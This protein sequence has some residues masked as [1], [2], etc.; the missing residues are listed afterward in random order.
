MVY[1]SNRRVEDFCGD[2][3]CEP[4]HVIFTDIPY[5]LSNTSLDKLLINWKQGETAGAKGFMNMDWDQIPPP[6][7]WA[8]LR[9]L[10]H[11]GAILATF[12]GTKNSDL[13]SLSIRL[14][15][16]ERIDSI[17]A[18]CYANG[19]PKSR[20]LS[21]YMEP[22]HRNKWKGYGTAL[23]PSVEP[24]LLFRNPKTLTFENNAIEYGAGAINVLGQKHPANLVVCH[25][26]ECRYVG[27]GTIRNSN[28]SVSGN[29][30]GSPFSHIY[31]DMSARTP[32]YAQ[33]EI[34][35]GR[36]E[37][38]HDC[39]VQA[40]NKDDPEQYWATPDWSYDL[41]ERL[42][43]PSLFYS[44]KA[45][46]NERECGLQTFSTQNVT[47]GRKTS[48]DNPFQRGKTRRKNT[49]PCVK[50]LALTQWIARLLLPPQQVQPK[51]LIPFSGS[52]SEVIGSLLA[53]WK[54]ITSVEQNT[55]YINLQ[56]ARINFWECLV[57]STGTNDI[58][59]LL[60]YSEVPIVDDDLRQMALFTEEEQHG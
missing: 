50:P 22:G 21:K 48:I 33:K 8:A 45:S 38:H 9:S 7:T 31:G 36:Y 6:S 28:G 19:F 4:F 34:H 49:H 32:F 46:T 56:R 27:K 24:I 12:S 30:P 35:I 42:K 1:L 15:G 16:W 14:S 25:H 40:L 11:P 18:W 52:G 3:L 5:G 54:D 39:Q 59:R 29:E 13:V 60:E 51:M 17:M 57:D 26:P 43:A 10:C 2:P 44:T 20:T 53:G 23:K 47:D 58:N 41:I 55:E 37:C